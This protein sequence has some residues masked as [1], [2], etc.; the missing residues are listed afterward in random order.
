MGGTAEEH[1]GGVD[2]PL[3]TSKFDEEPGDARKPV[4]PPVRILWL[5]GAAPALAAVLL[6]VDAVLINAVGYGVS[7]LLGLCALAVFYRV[8]ASR[9]R[10]KTYTPVPVVRWVVVGVGVACLGVAMVHMWFL[11][12]WVATR[13]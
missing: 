13:A 1:H 9:R 10:A 8:D 12:T 5:A 2:F 3:E 4:R 7:V 6:I 11:A